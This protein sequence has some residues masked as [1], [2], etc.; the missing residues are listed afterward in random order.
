MDRIGQGSRP[1]STIQSTNGGQAVRRNRA[2][3]KNARW[4]SRQNKAPE[5]AL[6]SQG[7]KS[8]HSTKPISRNNKASARTTKTC[9]IRQNVS[10]A[11]VKVLATR[12]NDANRHRT[13]KLPPMS[14]KDPRAP[15]QNKA[16]E[17]VHLFHAVF[18]AS[19]RGLS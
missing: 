16:S 6:G 9:E 4:A 12:S 15:S 8:M 5:R 17:A 10:L 19:G 2:C 3:A 7:C 13:G 18:F 1:T 14:K 11:A